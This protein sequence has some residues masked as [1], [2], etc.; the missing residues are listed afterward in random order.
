MDKIELT[1]HSHILNEA[2]KRE[3]CAWRYDGAYAVYNLPPYEEMKRKKMG[4]LNPQS[5]GNYRAWY[6][7]DLM[8]GFTNLLEEETEV[9]V[10]IGVSPGLCGKGYGQAILREASAISARLYPGKPLYL[11]VRTWNNR[12]VS[13]YRKAGFRIDGEPFEQTTGVGPGMFYR[14]V[15]NFCDADGKC[16]D[17]PTAHDGAMRCAE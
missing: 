11:Q 17:S 7:G 14:M 9:F 8:V 2:E 10:G 1:L 6:D 15:L 13:C 4:F 16:V 3:I 5:A 12:A